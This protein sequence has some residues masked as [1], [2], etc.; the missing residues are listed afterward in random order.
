MAADLAARSATNEHQL[1]VPGVV[2]VG[3]GV[4]D[5]VAQQPQGDRA[6]KRV[7]VLV[8]ECQHQ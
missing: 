2:A 5:R 6:C 3:S 1:H 8:D 4:D 7:S